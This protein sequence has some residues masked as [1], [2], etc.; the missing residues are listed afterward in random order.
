MWGMNINSEQMPL[1]VSRWVNDG[2][3][4]GDKSEFLSRYLTSRKRRHC[5]CHAVQFL[6]VCEEKVAGPVPT[7]EDEGEKTTIIKKMLDEQKN[8]LCGFIK[9]KNFIS[10]GI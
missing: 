7:R 1:R 2:N 3:V 9:L 6:R 4:G 5:H 8:K 10:F